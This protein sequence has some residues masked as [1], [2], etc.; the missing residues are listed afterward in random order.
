MAGAVGA[1]KNGVIVGIYVASRANSPG[2]TVSHTPPGVAEGRTCPGGRGVASRAVRCK[3]GWRGLMNGIRRGVVIRCVTPVAGRRHCCVVVVYVA[4]GASH[5]C[6]RPRK[7]KRGRAVIELAVSPDNRVVA[8]LTSGWESD[9]NMVHRSRCRV[10][11][12]EVAGDTCR[13]R[14]RQ[15]VVVVDVAVGARAGRS[16]VRVGKRESRG[17]VIEFPIAP[18]HRVVAA[19]TRRRKS[20]LCV[21]HWSRRRVVI[22]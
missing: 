18:L 5:F 15:A 2:V 4:A 20:Q 3:D 22:L 13:V 8:Q 19:F 17:R 11:V 6:V 9:L 7:W 12:V 21:V 14:A 16:G 1:R 10:V